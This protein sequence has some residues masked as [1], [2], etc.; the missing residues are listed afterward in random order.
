MYPNPFSPVHNALRGALQRPGQQ[1]GSIVRCGA[2]SGWKAREQGGPVCALPKVLG[3]QRD[4][5]A[6]QRKLNAA[7]GL[8]PRSHV[9]VPTMEWSGV[10]KCNTP[11]GSRVAGAAA[12]MKARV[13]DRGGCGCGQYGRKPAAGTSGKCG[14]QFRRQQTEH[15]TADPSPRTQRQ[16]HLPNQPSALPTMPS[17][18]FSGDI[19]AASGQGGARR[20]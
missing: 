1:G 6:P 7:Q 10:T 17:G 12:T 15:Q 18:R 3:R 14:S 16:R 11:T 8:P 20:G 2:P 13:L 9:E 5:V 4:S 19:L